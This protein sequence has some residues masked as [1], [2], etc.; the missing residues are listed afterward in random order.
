MMNQ[1]ISER[2]NLLNGP[3]SFTSNQI[4][5]TSVLEWGYHFLSSLALI[6]DDDQISATRIT[7]IPAMMTRL[8]IFE[9]FANKIQIVIKTYIY[10][11]CLFIR[12]RLG[13]I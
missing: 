10:T 9:I 5:N 8:K 1:V 3:P 2:A 11:S 13:L 6:P 7:I 4:A 12:I